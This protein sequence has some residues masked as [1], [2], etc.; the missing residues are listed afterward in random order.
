VP[1]TPSAKTYTLDGSYTQ[2]PESL[3]INDLSGTSLSGLSTDI[4]IEQ[5]FAGSFDGGISQ[6]RMYVSPLS[7]PEI[8]HNFK[9]NYANFQMFNPD[10]P[11]CT[12]LVCSPNDFEYSIFENGEL[13]LKVIISPGSINI[14]YLLIST[15]NPINEEINLNFRNILNKKDG[16]YYDIYSEVKISPYELSGETFV[17][18]NEDFNTLDG[19]AYFLDLSITPSGLS[20]NFS[21][22]EDIQF[23]NP[24][25]TPTQTSTPTPTQTS[26]PTPTQTSTPTP[27]QTSTPTPTITPTPEQIITDAIITNEVE[28]ISVGGLFYLKFVDPEQAINDAI[29]VNGDEY[30][31]V[32]ENLYLSFVDPIIVTPT[33]TNTNTPTVT[34]TSTITQTPTP[35][36]TPTISIT[37]S[38]TPTTTITPTPTK[39]P[40][41]VRQI[42]VPTL[43]NGATSI[44]SNTLQ[45]TQTSETLQIQVN[46][47]ITDNIGATSFVGIV[48]SDGTYTYVFTGPGGGL[49]FDCD[50][51]LTFSGTC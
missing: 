26:T 21:V 34:P 23:Q 5:N 36:N 8:K 11:D 9:I 35:T 24:T 51:P 16:G 7:A 38:I 28:Y 18:L 49:A 10:C 31:S 27:T 29:I 20:N 39:T 37:P 45:L 30:I 15:A 1:P 32:G 40:N 12:I 22:V 6:F 47:V 50:F 17:N 41:C 42:V 33:P 48:S 2:D 14:Q 25:P 46:D 4:I 13:I 44:N 19:T 43:W 3:P